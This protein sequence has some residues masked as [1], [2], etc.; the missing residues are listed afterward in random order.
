MLLVLIVLLVEVLVQTRLQ[1][2]EPV[3]LMSM[4]SPGSIAKA[5]RTTV[6]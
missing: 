5:N 3:L 6:G 2:I 1:V 4:S